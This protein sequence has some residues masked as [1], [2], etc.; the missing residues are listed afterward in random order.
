VHR[1][2]GVAL[3]SLDHIEVILFHRFCKTGLEVFLQLFRQLLSWLQ[4][5]QNTEPLIDAER[6]LEFIGLQ[7]FND[8]DSDLPIVR[9]SLDGYNRLRNVL[10]RVTD[11]L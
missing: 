11:K 7:L 10:G 9:P 5:V 4:Y 1:P 3:N 2:F 8:L 6:Y